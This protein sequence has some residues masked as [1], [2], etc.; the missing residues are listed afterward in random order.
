ML[1]QGIIKAF[2]L[3]L[4][5]EMPRPLQWLLETAVE[6]KLR[7]SVPI[8]DY[9][10]AHREVAETLA[11]EIAKVLG[12]RDH[13]DSS[14]Y[15][16]RFER[17]FARLSRRR[18]AVGT[19]SGTAALE[20][21]LKAF[22]IGPGDEV[23]TVPNSYIASSLCISNTGAT[24]VFVDIDPA[25]YNMDPAGI[26]K[27]VTAK[28]KAILPVYLY[29]QMADMP[30][31]EGIARSQGLKVIVDACQA[32]GAELAGRG[33]GAFGDAVCYSFSTPKTLGGLGNGGIIVTDDREAA[34]LV[35]ELRD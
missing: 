34:R 29:G 31:I 20:L 11:T 13:I 1:K 9:S 30:A 27:A 3:F 22:G 23:I 19:N 35:R 10:R 28:T 18:Y 4:R 14:F 6:T 21:S 32:Y 25:S 5:S 2:K 24:P 16:R 15:Q 8:N 26:A 17:D 7:N 12:F 33:S